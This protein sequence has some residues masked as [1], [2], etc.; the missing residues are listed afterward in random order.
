MSSLKQLRQ[1]L[2]IQDESGRRLF[3]PLGILSRPRVIPDPGAEDWLLRDWNRVS[4]LIFGPSAI[5]LLGGLVCYLQHWYAWSMALLLTGVSGAALGTQWH[6]RSSS[7][8]WER[9]PRLPWSRWLR[10]RAVGRL[11]SHLLLEAASW[12]FLL[13][14]GVQILRTGHADMQLLGWLQTGISGVRLAL[15]LGQLAYRP[16]PTPDPPVAC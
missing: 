6:F 10:L 11:L 8:S 12:A 14:V 3:F 5:V 1:H 2:V 13:F 4:L 9:L 16:R 7:Q 15:T